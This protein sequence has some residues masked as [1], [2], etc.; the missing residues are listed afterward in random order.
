MH[1]PYQHDLTREILNA[2]RAQGIAP[3]IYFSPDDFRWLWKNKIDIQRGI[4][5]VQPRNIR[6]NILQAIMIIGLNSACC[7]T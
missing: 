3:G 5:G 1:T 7:R 2:F 4:P 6:G